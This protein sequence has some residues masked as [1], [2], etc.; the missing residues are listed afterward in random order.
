MLFYFTTEDTKSTE[1]CVITAMAAMGFSLRLCDF[2][3]NMLLFI[4]DP[5][6]KNSPASGEAGQRELFCAFAG[7][8]NKSLTAYSHPTKLRLG[9]KHFFFALLRLRGKLFLPQRS[10]RFR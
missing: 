7:I 5:F 2:E 9:V 8:K 6:V 4:L 3:G 10:R 1:N